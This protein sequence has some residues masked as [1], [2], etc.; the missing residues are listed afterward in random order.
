MDDTN[1]STKDKQLEKQAKVKEFIELLQDPNVQQYLANMVRK[2][3][4]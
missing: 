4:R 1:K 2:M 3:V